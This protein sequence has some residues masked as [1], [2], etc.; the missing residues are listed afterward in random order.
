M[1]IPKA[2]LN[3]EE[4]NFTVLFTVM[5]GGREFLLVRQL[6]VT[7]SPGIFLTLNVLNYSYAHTGYFQPHVCSFILCRVSCKLH[8]KFMWKKCSCGLPGQ[9]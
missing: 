1:S 7:L 3:S 6:T 2:L 9:F 4:D 8:S 5:C